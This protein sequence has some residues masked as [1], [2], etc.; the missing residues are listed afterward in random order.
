MATAMTKPDAQIKESIRNLLKKKGLQVEDIPETRVKTPDFYIDQGKPDGS[1]LE[2]KTKQ[3]DP[4]ELASISAELDSMGLASRTKPIEYWNRLDGIISSSIKQLQ[5]KDPTHKIPHFVWIHCEGLEAELYSMQLKA[6]LYGSQKLFTENDGVGM[7][8][9]YYFGNS[10]FFKHRNYLDGVVI[11]REGEAQL[12]LNELSPHFALAR[13]SSL[14]KALEPAVFYPTKDKADG[15]LINDFT[16]KRN[17]KQK[18]LIYLQTKY[19]IN[20]LQTIPMNQ[21]SVMMR[22]CGS[23]QAQI[24]ENNLSP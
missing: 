2:V 18:N 4:V 6:T 5:E 9:C 11:S 16:G 23:G 10:S 22:P 19:A 1:L 14:A 7:I 12:N 17:D 24:E 20:H 13:N 3:D 15:D 8:T 21:D